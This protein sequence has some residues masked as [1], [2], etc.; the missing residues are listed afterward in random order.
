MK[1]VEGVNLAIRFLCE[2]AALVAVAYWGY[3]T[4][5]GPARWGLALLAPA[6]VVGVWLFFVT[7]DPVIEL[8][9]PLQF[10]IELGVWAAATAALL[11]TGHRALAVVFAILAVGSG[12]LNYLFG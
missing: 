7:P 5:P 11:A 12:T 10:A 6:A 3:R 9:R 2:V 4:G 1:V 8:A